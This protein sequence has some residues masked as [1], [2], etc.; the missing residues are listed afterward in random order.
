MN[1]TDVPRR[2]RVSLRLA[3]ATGICLLLATG[4]TL[5]FSLQKPRGTPLVD[6]P[7]PLATWPWPAAVQDQ[8]HAGI[9]HWLDRSSPDG[10]LLDLLEF[11]FAANPRLRLELYDQDEDDEVPF[12]NRVDY[13]P[14]GVAEAVQHLDRAGRGPVLAAWNGLFFA[15]KGG[16]WGEGGVGY[17]VAPVVL[18]GQVRHNVGNHR[19]TFGVKQAVEGPE[20]KL[21]HLPDRATLSREFTYAAAGA[22]AILREGQPLRVEPIPGPDSPARPFPVPSTPQ[23]AGYIPGVDHIKTCRTSMG[24]SRDHQQFYL[25][26]VKEPDRELAS[27]IDQR[28]GK[29]MQGGWSLADL[30]RFWQARGVWSA[31]NLDGGNVTQLLY[32]RADGRY[33]LVPPRWATD[34]LRQTLNSDLAGAPKGGTLMYFYIR[35]TADEN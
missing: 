24:W 14:R 33:E 2:F 9:T 16:A 27:K 20:F 17:P 21:L 8:P 1:K 15:T 12:D 26:V 13:W 32:R 35:E 19:W 23:E 31:V 34:A 30:Q 7:S 3:S 25:L 29:P 18:Q 28:F 11:D 22:Q 5:L 4:A 10:T 6:P